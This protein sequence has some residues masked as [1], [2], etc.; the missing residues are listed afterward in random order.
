MKSVCGYGFLCL[1]AFRVGTGSIFSVLKLTSV[2]SG[3]WL[4][5]HLSIVC[6][7]SDYLSQRAKLDQNDFLWPHVCLRNYLRFLSPRLHSLVLMVKAR[8]YGE[9]LFLEL[10]R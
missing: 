5:L 7:V 8:K 4:Y 3:A 1:L 10:Y 6:N 2:V 9:C